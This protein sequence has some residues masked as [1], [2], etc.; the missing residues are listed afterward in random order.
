MAM[1]SVDL[2]NIRIKT[3]RIDFPTLRRRTGQVIQSQTSERAAQWIGI[4]I[5]VFSTSLV[6]GYRSHI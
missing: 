3:G 1:T 2:Y 5:N 6:Y 4:I